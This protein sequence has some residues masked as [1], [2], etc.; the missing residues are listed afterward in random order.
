MQKSQSTLYK[1]KKQ[2][3]GSKVHTTKTKITVCS[4]KNHHL[5]F[6][7]NETQTNTL[8]NCIYSP[9]DSAAFYIISCL[10]GSR[11]YDQDQDTISIFSLYNCHVG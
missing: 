6:G 5:L 1:N 9:S 11:S 8:N 10:S 4:K 2:K 3:D 7:A